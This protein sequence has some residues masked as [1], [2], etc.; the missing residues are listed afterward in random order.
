ME[1]D[2][3]TDD[4]AQGRLPVLRRHRQRAL[5]EQRARREQ[6]RRAGAHRA[7]AAHRARQ[8]RRE[9][10]GAGR[11]GVR[12]A[13]GELRHRARPARRARREELRRRH[14]LHAG[15]AGA[16]HRHAARPAD[17]G[18][19]P[20]R[21]ERAQDAWQVD[22]DH[23]RGDEPLVPQRHELPRRHQHADDV[24]LHRPE[25]RWLG[26]L[27]GPGE[28][29][30]ADRLDAAGLRARLDPPAAPDEQHQLLLRPH[31]PVALREARHGRGALA[32]GRQDALRR[33]HD[34]LQRARRAHGLA[35][36]G[37]AVADQSD[38]GGARRRSGGPGRRRTTR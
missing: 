30:P 29:A 7:R 37:A 2:Y 4:T 22:G 17:H 23:R 9:A 32:A 34:R 33:Q 35:A 13:G 3:P 27:R 8:G 20:V 1:G 31:R 18:R 12:P 21:R 6:H 15:L 14:A 10:R 11:H 16:H 19:P 26:A 25:R 38:A 5:P 36:F 24:R 28:A